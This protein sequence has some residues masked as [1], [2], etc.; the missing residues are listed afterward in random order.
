M[1]QR[2]MHQDVCC[3]FGMRSRVGNFESTVSATL[4][5]IICIFFCGW[6]NLNEMGVGGIV[7]WKLKPQTKHCGGH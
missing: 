3:N 6:L 2:K 7:L 1:K 4:F 5:E